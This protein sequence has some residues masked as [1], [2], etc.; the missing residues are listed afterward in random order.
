MKGFNMHMWIICVAVVTEEASTRNSNLNSVK[1]SS[2]PIKNLIISTD[3]AGLLN[4]VSS[5]PVFSK[6]VDSNKHCL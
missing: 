6:E 1:L 5:D 2:K 4:I 3:W